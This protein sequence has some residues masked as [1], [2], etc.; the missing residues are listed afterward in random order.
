M[1]AKGAD[2]VVPKEPQEASKG[3]IAP[4]ALV[5]EYVRG[6]VLASGGCGSVYRARHRTLGVEVAIK[7]LHASLAMEPKMVER[8]FREVEMVNLLRHP[9]IVEIYELGVL[10]DKRPFYVMEYLHGGTLADLLLAEGRLSAAHALEIIRPVCTALDAAHAAGVVHR[11]VKA[12]NIAFTG[13]PKAV[14]LLD[15]GIAKLLSPTP[16]YPG[17]TSVGRQLGTPGIMAPEQ[18]LGGA[19]DGRVDIYAL[20]VLLY[21]V[22]TGRMPFESKSPAELARKHLEEPAPRPSRLIAMPPALDAVVIRCLEKRPEHRFASVNALI[23]AFAEALCGPARRQAPTGGLEA[24]GVAIY[25][26]VRTR[27]SGDEFDTAIACELG[28]ILDLVEESLLR[29]GFFLSQVTGNG[30]LGVRPVR[31]GSNKARTVREAA[32]ELA[33]EL[34]KDIANLPRGPTPIYVN[35]ALHIDEVCLDSSDEPEILGGAL[36]RTALW[37]PQDEVLGIS[38]TPALI[39]GITGFEQAV[40]VKHIPPPA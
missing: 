26:D 32:I 20:G 13:E 27:T 39:E 11:D 2:L 31:G 3:E 16:D 24:L 29:G 28:T 25:V 34:R 15:F 21:R 35:I 5:G 8:F 19:M 36:L 30:V 18:L 17:L 7:V 33:I 14:K 9:N 37:A 22:L 12:S 6:D 10:A 38:V 40:T 1:E 23:N 4:G